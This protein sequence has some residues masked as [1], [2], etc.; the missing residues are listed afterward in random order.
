[1]MN[2]EQ[3]EA[4]IT[5]HFR[6]KIRKDNKIYHASLLVHSDRLGIHL[7]LAEGRSAAFEIHADQ[8]FY[9]ASISKLFTSVLI[10]MLVEKGLLAYDEPISR[11]LDKDLLHQLHLVRGKDYTHEILIRH[12]LN[13]TS[14]LHCFFEDRPKRVKSMID[15]IVD[16]PE[17]T[18]TPLETLQWG[19]SHLHGHFRPGQGFHYSDTGY[20]L[21][22]LIIENVMKLPFHDVIHIYIF[23]P[24]RMLH[25]YVAP[26]QPS[27]QNEHPIAR[28][29]IRDID[30]TD[31]DS[32]SFMF[33]G[34]GIVSTTEDLL[35]FMR[36]LVHHEL[37][38]S[39][40]IDTMLGDWARFFP[41]IDYGYG[42][43]RFRAIPLLM[44]A[45]YQAWG[46]AGSTGSFMFY[47]PATD[48]YFIG[49]LNQFRYHQK[50]IRLMMQTI[51]KLLKCDA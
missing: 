21:L 50:G 25:S 13:H 8:P 51:D 45:R 41:G 44:P 17:R 6:K 23:T 16:E 1:M 46:N 49:S 18:W 35:R 12:L 7:N 2:K 30:V 28:L 10:G 34:G 22:G 9:I 33:A 47:H 27:S 24:L 42:V 37:I 31:Y 5:E 39:E 4:A 48:A 20:H 3:T 19:K 26:G 36:A 32:L 14:G 11:Y 43:M 40:T 29:F 38:R 15:M